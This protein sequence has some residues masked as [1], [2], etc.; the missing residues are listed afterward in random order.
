M[1]NEQQKNE[2]QLI[3]RRRP[4]QPNW[5]AIAEKTFT[6][7]TSPDDE[8]DQG[9][10]AAVTLCKYPSYSLHPTRGLAVAAT[11]G[12][13]GYCGWMGTPRIHYVMDLNEAVAH[14]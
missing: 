6:R 11:S 13:C 5:R 10:F 2:Q 8:D 12:S 3:G 4:K 1:N 9:R 14:A 7:M